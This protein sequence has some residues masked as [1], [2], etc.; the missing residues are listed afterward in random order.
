MCR[1]GYFCSCG[2]DLPLWPERLPSTNHMVYIFTLCL[3]VLASPVD[4]G[5]WLQFRKVGENCGIH[6]LCALRRQQW[7]LFV[8]KAF[9]LRQKRSRFHHPSYLLGSQLSVLGSSWHAI[10]P[11]AKSAKSFK[12]LL[13]AAWPLP[14]TTGAITRNRSSWEIITTMSNRLCFATHCFDYW[15]A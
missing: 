11:L 9:L 4:S 7:R 1:P 13:Q 10:N 5:S 14:T 12:L 2:C 15:L 3:M 6:K 8:Q